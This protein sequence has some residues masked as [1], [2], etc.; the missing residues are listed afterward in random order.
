[1]Q[2]LRFVGYYENGRLP[3]AWIRKFLWSDKGVRVDEKIDESVFRWFDH[4]E[5]MGNNMITK[6]MNA[7]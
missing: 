4:I 1:M 2:L 6:M 3:N 5:R 7:E